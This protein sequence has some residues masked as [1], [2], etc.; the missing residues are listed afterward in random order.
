MDDKKTILIVDDNVLNQK[1]YKL[2][3]GF[4]KS[5]DLHF[6][7]DGNSALNF[8]YHKDS[9]DLVLMDDMIPNSD[10]DLLSKQIRKHYSSNS[11]D[12]PIVS[13]TTNPPSKEEKK[14]GFKYDDYLLLP[15]TKNELLS[16]VQSYLK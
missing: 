14:S 7:T 5:Y 8:V 13:L 3:L 16:M 12:V 6:A 11:I 9:I 15:V 10:S 1:V 4:E 2:M